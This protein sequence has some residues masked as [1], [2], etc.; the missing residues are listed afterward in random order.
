M[1]FLR[2]TKPT[3]VDKHSE[4]VILNGATALEVRGE[5]S[6]Q[7]PLEALAGGHSREGADRPVIAILQR[8]PTNKYDPNAIEVL[9]RL[10]KQPDKAATLVGYIAREK[11][12]LM[13]PALDRFEA[14]EQRVALR[15]RIIGGW[16]RGDGDIGHFGIWLKY[17]PSDFA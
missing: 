13:A 17:T 6:Y 14:N 16:D 2:R 11:A 4:T 3:A 10:E 5:A 8:E 9:A 7:P 12:A 1:S 15:G